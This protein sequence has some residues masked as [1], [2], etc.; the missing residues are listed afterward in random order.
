MCTSSKE[1]INSSNEVS[2]KQLSIEVIIIIVITV[3]AAH[4]DPQ[5]ALS[6]LHGG[7]QRME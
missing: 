7:R 3:N 2:T 5:E 1:V 4:G 6:V